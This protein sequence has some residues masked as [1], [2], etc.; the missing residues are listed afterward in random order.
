MKVKCF[1]EQHENDLSDAIN[2]FIE[3]K[4]VINIKFSTSCF[5]NNDEQIYCFSA[6]VLY[7]E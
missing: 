2:E 7:E 4:K 6:L 3:N 1:D 5:K